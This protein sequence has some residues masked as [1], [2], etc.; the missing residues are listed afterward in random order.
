L[1]WTTVIL[2]MCTIGASGTLL[3]AAGEVMRMRQW[4]LNRG[5]A[6][7]HRGRV[8]IVVL[9]TIFAISTAIALPV[10]FLS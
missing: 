7:D 10:I 3:V 1:N 8:V 5:I 2:V 4:S 6:S 9:S